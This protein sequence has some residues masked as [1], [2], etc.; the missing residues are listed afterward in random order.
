MNG[1]LTSENVRMV[2]DLVMVR[3]FHESEELTHGGMHI[4]GSSQM[5]TREAEVVAVGRGRNRKGRKGWFFAP[6]HL[7]PGD[8]VWIG[9]MSAAGGNIRMGG[10]DY[11]VMREDDVLAL[12]ED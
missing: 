11:Y 12:L 1:K 2:Q 6:T 4:P 7:R 3:R 8:K 10:E 9:R 5:R